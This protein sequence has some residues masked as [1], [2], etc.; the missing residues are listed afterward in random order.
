[1]SNEA[2][3]KESKQGGLNE[4]K[5]RPYI[6][7]LGGYSIDGKYASTSIAKKYSADFSDLTEELLSN[8]S[9]KVRLDFVIPHDPPIF[10]DC[11]STGCASKDATD[12][13]TKA[14]CFKNKFPGCKIYLIYH[15]L[16]KEYVGILEKLVSANLID[17]YTK[18]GPEK[19]LEN[20]VSEGVMPK[21]N[22][23][24]FF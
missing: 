12:I 13:A 23:N 10:I 24:K 20:A 2:F 5:L 3:K 6:E 7:S 4:E 1:M 17:G 9:K 11:K 8:Y 15:G 18:N 21:S 16:K 19:L 22:I 14:Q